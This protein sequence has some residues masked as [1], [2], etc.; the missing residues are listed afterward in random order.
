M[1]FLVTIHVTLQSAWQ[2]EE[3]HAEHTVVQ[4]ISANSLRDRQLVLNV[5]RLT[6][7]KSLHPWLTK[8]LNYHGHIP[9]ELLL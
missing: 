1:T 8:I 7:V 2:L 9:H 4:K 3:S 5:K 6:A